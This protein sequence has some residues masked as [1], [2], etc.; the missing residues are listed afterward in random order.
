MINNL[1]ER[2]EESYSNGWIKNKGIY[3]SLSKKVENAKKA[4]E[5]GK[6]KT[7]QNK[8]ESYQHELEA[9]R[10]K[11]VTEEGYDYMYYY[12]GEIIERF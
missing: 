12:A 10:G 4:N 8:L 9:Q 5:K 7:V 1:Q 2:T 3:N 6:N 11:H